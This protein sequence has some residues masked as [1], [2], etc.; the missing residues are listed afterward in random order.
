MTMAN[1]NGI[2]FC[3]CGVEGR[4]AAEGGRKPSMCT[5]NIVFAK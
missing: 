3:A 1:K 4:T 2:E 5:G